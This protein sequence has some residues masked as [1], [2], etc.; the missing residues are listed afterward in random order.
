MRMLIRHFTLH[1]LTGSRAPLSPS[2]KF[3]ILLFRTSTH[4]KDHGYAEFT[5]FRQYSLKIF[6][7]VNQAVNSSW[8]RKHHKIIE[9]FSGGAFLH[10]EIT[11]PFDT[12]LTGAQVENDLLEC[13][14]KRR[15][16]YEK[17]GWQSFFEET[18]K[19]GTRHRVFI[20]LGPKKGQLK[21][22]YHADLLLPLEAGVL[23]LA[24]QV[25]DLTGA[26]FFQFLFSFKSY[27]YSVI[28][29][30]G[31]PFHLL[32]V[33]H[34][35]GGWVSKLSEHTHISEAN[36]QSRGAIKTYVVSSVDQELYK[37]AMDIADLQ[38]IDIPMCRRVKETDAIIHCG[39][40]LA[41]VHKELLLHNRAPAAHV[42]SNA[43]CRQRFLLA[44]VTG[45]VLAL[46]LMVSGSSLF[47]RHRVQAQLAALQL[48]ADT[49]RPAVIRIE[50]EYKLMEALEDTLI[51]YKDL[52]VPAIP[53][54]M[55]F[56]GL[57]KALPDKSGIDGF[58]MEP[59]SEG[60]YRLTFKARVSGWDGVSQFKTRLGKTQ[61]F[62][63]I[64]FSDQQ[65]NP[66]TNVVS[67]HVSCVVR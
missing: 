48:K 28:F 34:T 40:L 14:G 9:A 63:Q 6:S 20:T 36:T 55:V 66:K 61:Y 5:S 18:T 43:S 47:Y 4:I 21:N 59:G 19:Q 31:A 65:L 32:R 39:V 17:A 45:W 57:N 54:D 50:R 10:R 38:L 52:W 46:T 13:L 27:H 3:L 24:W 2:S 64:S 30:G 37:T 29:L 56:T 60:Q 44:Q 12:E 15:S 22:E 26:G 58:I 41:G 25:H 11:I 1:N 35:E 67:F 49:Y 8:V 51:A 16:E 53:W 62:Q 42:S 23:A 33:G 7:E